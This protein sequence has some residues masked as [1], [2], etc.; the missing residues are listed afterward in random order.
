MYRAYAGILES[1]PPSECTRLYP[2]LLLREGMQNEYIRSLQMYLSYI[3]QFDPNIDPVANTGYF[4][5]L[6]KAA[7]QS[8]QREYGLTANGQVGAVTWDAITGVYSEMRCG[9][10]KRPY[11]APGYIIR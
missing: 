6:T 8:F 3:A 9:A 1:V 7:V 2:N 4:G 5:P 10:N 11:Q